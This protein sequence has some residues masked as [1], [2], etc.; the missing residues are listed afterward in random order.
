MI[1]LSVDAVRKHFGPESVLGGV[2]FEVRPG[3]RIGLVGPNGSG[4][5]T[6]LRILAGRE[7]ADS[8]TCEIHP[9]V[10]LGYLG[11]QLVVEAGRTLWE[12][13]RGALAPLIALES[14]LLDVAHSLSL[15]EDDTEHRRLAARYDHLHQE[16]HRH[17]AYNLDHRIEEVLDGLK[18]RRQ[19]FE[20]PVESLS[21]GEQNRL[22][23]AKLLL[24]EPDLMLLD[25]PSNHLDV[26]A[27]E[28]LEDFLAQNKA[29]MILV[30]HDRYFLDKVTTR[31][32]E[33]FHGT[34][35]SYPGNF[36]AY[37]R[38][39]AER[40]VVQR[41]TYEKQQVEIAKAKEF[42]RRNAYG[43]KHAQAE[44]RRKKLDRLEPVELP[45]EIATPLM[46]F[47]PAA[48]SGDIV[49]RV[50]HLSK[51]YDRPLFEDVSFDVARGERWG[52]LGPNG[53]GKTTLLRCLIG[54]MEPDGG[55]VVVGHGV[56]IG[57][58]D[59]H[60]STLADHAR[61]VD[62]IRPPRGTFEEK[63]RRDLLARF[64][65][66]GEAALQTA[67]SLS[68]GE[69]CRAA[70]AR[71]S[72][73]EANLLVLDEP[74]N[75]LD[76]WARDALERSLRAFQGTVLFVSHDRYFLDQVADHLLVIE[77]PGELR[78]VEG[79]YATYQQL[80]GRSVDGTSGERNKPYEGGGTAEPE[81]RAVKANNAAKRPRKRRRFRYRKI[82]DLEREIF[83]RE[84]RID[85]L[86]ALLAEPETLRDG[87]QVRR[88]KDEIVEQQQTLETLYAHWE[89][90]TEL[91]G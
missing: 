46:D 48:R 88:F 49:L 29:A 31:T 27:T 78:V 11:Q 14:E 12:E 6:L 23:L 17:D 91:D 19:V 41:R 63:K 81:K 66:T 20:Q 9:S 69:R 4:K 1:L 28:W 18:F 51:A 72:A 90:A 25:E 40:L 8:G 55:R 50:E 44:D 52:M 38:Q 56:R 71:L 7:E 39:R 32:L 86:H 13:A 75:H 54:Q 82:D 45:R 64:G 58:F 61:V 36:S 85:E 30:S 5:T 79:N 87:P 70:L 2:G 26:E 43:Q 83:E 80:L 42:I 15:A 59:Q 53:S 57:Y 10:R 68:G 47:P 16:L 62:A 24:G 77:R 35:E 33:L 22:M 65:L 76:L 89:E 67:G 84:T 37:R 34:V 3:E 74:T 73:A 21:G 60:L